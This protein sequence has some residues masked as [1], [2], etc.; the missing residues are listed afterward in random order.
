VT[1]ELANRLIAQGVSNTRLYTII[2]QC[3]TEHTGEEIA[4]AIAYIR[5]EIVLG[6]FQSKTAILPT[7]PAPKRTRKVQLEAE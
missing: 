7:K 5:A 6:K 3:Y 2:K 4:E 1:E